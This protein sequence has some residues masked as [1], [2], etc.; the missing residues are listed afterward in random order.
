[1]GAY[2]LKETFKK[3]DPDRTELANM[4]FIA[5]LAFV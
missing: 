5:Y 2:Q 1:M 3:S 4:Y